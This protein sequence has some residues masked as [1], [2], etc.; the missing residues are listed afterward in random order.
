MAVNVK[1]RELGKM[2]VLLFFYLYNHKINWTLHYSSAIIEINGN[3]GGMSV[4]RKLK[5]KIL[6]FMLLVLSGVLF[7]HVQPAKAAAKV[8]VKITAKKTTMKVGDSYVFKA[9]KKGTK[10]SIRWSVSNTRLASINSKTGK[11][12]AK[13]T[14]K[15]TVYAKAS[16]KTAKCTVLIKKADIKITE[17]N[18]WSLLYKA[19][20]KKGTISK[21]KKCA[22][23]V[24]NLSTTEFLVTMGDNTPDKFTANEHFVVN[25]KT[26]KAVALFSTIVVYLK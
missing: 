22:Y 1:I 19:L 10:K 8:S 16:N 6:L 14:G 17:K 18:V 15:I 23:M 21:N 13:R 25:K 9:Q 3:K 24:S 12:S 5:S 7:T 20:V 4:K 11:L 26:G 2:S